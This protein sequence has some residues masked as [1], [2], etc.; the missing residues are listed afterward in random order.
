MK[1][2]LFIVAVMT[3]TWSHVGFS[4]G[5]EVGPGVGV[6]NWSQWR[7]SDGSGVS[8][9]TTCQSNGVR[10]A[11]SPGNTT[12]RGHSSPIVTRIESFRNP[13]G[14]VFLRVRGQA[15]DQWSGL[16]APGRCQRRSQRGPWRFMSRPV[17]QIFWE[18]TSTAS[19]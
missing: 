17:R 2:L 10:P 16:Q 4:S 9:E 1:R 14:S 12:G 3:G 5:S 6:S 8:T 15:Q 18:K 11:T 7:G 13:I 19:L